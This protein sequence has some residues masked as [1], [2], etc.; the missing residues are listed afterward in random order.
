MLFL[1]P[2]LDSKRIPLTILKNSLRSLNA[3]L[4][5]SCRSWRTAWRIWRIPFKILRD[6][7]NNLKKTKSVTSCLRVVEGCR[8][9][10]NNA[11]DQNRKSAGEQNRK[12]AR[13]QNRKSAKGQNRKSAKWLNRKSM[14]KQNRK[15][16][17]AHRQANYQF[18]CECL[19]YSLNRSPA[20]K[21]GG[22]AAS[23]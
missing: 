4:R 12:S 6:F 5:I 23:Q 22:Q 11:E 21:P 8:V 7:L 9:A 3:F 10:Q 20:S 19:P 13:D 18:C 2:P 16:A 15:S 14:K 17:G 1:R